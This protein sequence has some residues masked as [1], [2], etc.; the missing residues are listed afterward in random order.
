MYN[1]F[2][3]GKAPSQMMEEK[4]ANILD[5]RRANRVFK[6]T[7]RFQKHLS[8]NFTKAL[9]LARR[10]PYF[11]EEGQGDFYRV[12]ASFFPADV[13]ELHE[14]FQLIHEHRNTVVFLNNKRIPYLQDLWLFLMWFYKI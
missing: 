4:L 2:M 12:Y 7:L 8:K 14:L 3:T 13:R 5:P 10:N 1:P 11:M 6:I 9:E